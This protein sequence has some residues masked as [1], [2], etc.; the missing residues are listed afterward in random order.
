LISRS[1]P[2]PSG[3]L[4]LGETIWRGSGHDE[5]RRISA[6]ELFDRIR[7]VPKRQLRNGVKLLRTVAGGD[8][9]NVELKRWLCLYRTTQ[10]H[11]PRLLGVSPS[12]GGLDQPP[13]RAAP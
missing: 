6:I 2:L 13:L 3:G 11:S 10:A 7:R 9:P 8:V 12:A 5:F 1:Q 4:V